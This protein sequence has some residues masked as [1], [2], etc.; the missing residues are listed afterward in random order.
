MDRGNGRSTADV[1]L[2]DQQDYPGLDRVPGYDSRLERALTQSPFQ[3]SDYIGVVRLF[4]NLNDPAF[5]VSTNLDERPGRFVSRFAVR[6]ITEAYER[7]VVNDPRQLI[8]M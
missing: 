6:N 5:A 4:Q 8:S 7:A 1:D 3:V 2:L